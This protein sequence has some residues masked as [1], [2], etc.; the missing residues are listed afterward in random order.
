MSSRR[1]YIGHSTCSTSGA[2][3]AASTIVVERQLAFGR[4][5]LARGATRVKGCRGVKSVQQ[6]SSGRMEIGI[7]CRAR[8]ASAMMSSLAMP[9]SGR[10]REQ[11]GGGADRRRGC[12]AS[13]TPPA[14]PRRRSRAP[15]RAPSG[16]AGRRCAASA[17]GRRRRASAA[18]TAIVTC[19]CSSPNGMSITCAPSWYGASTPHQLAHLV[20]R[21][22]RGERMA[23]EVDERGVAAAPH[24]PPRRH[25]RVDAARQQHQHA[26]AGAHRQPAGAGLLAEVVVGAPR[27]RSR[28]RR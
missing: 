9:T 13:A 25:R 24:H 28:P 11:V 3:A 22:V 2:A 14:P 21:G 12:R 23:V 6:S 1:F 17:A 27:A 20:D 16:R 8:S 26:A 19:R 15:G 10:T 7:A 5:D 18:G 4:F